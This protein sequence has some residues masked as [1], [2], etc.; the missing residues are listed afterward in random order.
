M[1]LLPSNRCGNAHSESDVTERKLDSRKEHRVQEKP[2][3]KS[4]YLS[5]KVPRYMGYGSVRSLGQVYKCRFGVGV[6]GGRNL[7]CLP[8]TKAY[9]QRS[10][11]IS[12]IV[13]I[14][15]VS[16]ASITHDTP[17][18][19]TGLSVITTLNIISVAQSHGE[20]VPDRREPWTRR[21]VLSSCVPA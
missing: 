12:G 7:P 3:S 18:T 1:R 13:E 14:R 21:C 2:C 11:Q 20:G 8:P 19:R 16:R 4:V 9:P 17:P 15:D 10:R 5:G 6:V